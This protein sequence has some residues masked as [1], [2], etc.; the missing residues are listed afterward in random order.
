M[1]TLRRAAKLTATGTRGVGAIYR[2]RPRGDEA[3][4]KTVQW[5]VFPP[6]AR[7]RLRGPGGRARS[8]LLWV[9][10]TEAGDCRFR[11]TTIASRQQ[12]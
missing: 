12:N 9:N 5:T 3:D 1:R 8:D 2:A 11:L 6:N 10:L 7:A 4:Q